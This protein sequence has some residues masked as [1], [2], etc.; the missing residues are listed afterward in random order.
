M[1]VATDE[2]DKNNKKNAVVDKLVDLYRHST[3]PWPLGNFKHTE[4]QV[5][6][7]YRTYKNPEVTS[8]D[9]DVLRNLLPAILTD[10]SD[11]IDDCNIYS[12]YEACNACR[13]TNW[14]Q[15]K[16]DFFKFKIENQIFFYL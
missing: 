11:S 3:E 12:L 14:L 4:I 5:E 9:K 10:N 15:N 8:S 6:A 7:L 13:K 16:K 1:P 2:K